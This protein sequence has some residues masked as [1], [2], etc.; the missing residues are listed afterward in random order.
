MALS[1]HRSRPSRTL[2]RKRAYNL[3]NRKRSSSHWWPR[4]VGDYDR[5]TGQISLQQHGAYALLLDW[6]YSNESP[7]PL[8]MVQ[9]HRI[10]KAI[11]PT[12]QAD[13]QTVVQ[14]FFVAMDDG[15]HNSRADEE[16]GKRK[17][18]SD[19]RRLAQAEKERK[20]LANAGANAP[21]DAPTTTSTPTIE[22]E[23]APISPPEVEMFF[24]MIWEAYPGRGKY[25]ATGAGFKGNR[26]KALEKFTKLLKTEKD[27]DGFTKELIAG[28]Y[29]YRDFLDRTGTPS[30]HLITW[31]NGECWKDDF[32]STDGEGPR[33]G[34]TGG[35]LGVNA[36]ALA[37]GVRRT[38]RDDGPEGSLFRD[39][40]P[41]VS[42]NE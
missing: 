27:H 5:K 18:I 38:M 10:C 19:V 31:L 25:G 40:I 9:L 29:V 1:G 32:S 37:E 7:L 36:Q 3:D 17:H 15:Y 16:L 35:G 8:E 39:G 22:E 14:K 26:K 13:V 30:K 28:A 21:S 2:W 33:A 34:N 41:P 6:Y 24:C 42:A 12:E 11:A 20:R 23:R 4:Y